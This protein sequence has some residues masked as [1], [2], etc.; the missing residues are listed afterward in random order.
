MVVSVGSATKDNE[1]AYESLTCSATTDVK[2]AAAAVPFTKPSAK[3]LC[4][5]VPRRLGGAGTG[6]C[7]S[8]TRSCAEAAGRGYGG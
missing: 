3:R 6:H 7:G 5:H 8:H 1:Q 2:R 4:V